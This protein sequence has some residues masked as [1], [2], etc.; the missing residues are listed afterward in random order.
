MR[1]W[2]LV[3]ALM[4][5]GFAQAQ[6]EAAPPVTVTPPPTPEEQ[7]KELKAVSTDPAAVKN[8]TPPTAAFIVGEGFRILSDDGDYKLRVGFQGQLAYQPTF[9]RAPDG[10][11]TNN[12]SQFRVPFARLRVDGHLFK[13][14]IR[15]WFSFEF[16]N[17]PPFLLDGYVEWMPHKMFGIRL[18]Q[19]WTPMSRHEYLG[20]Q[21]MLFPD[22]AVTA[23]Y[24]W[25]GRDKGVQLF[26]EGDLIWWYLALFAGS[27]QRQPFTT[28][29]NFQLQARVTVNP[30][31]PLGWA[32]LPFAMA[33]DGKVPLRISFNLQGHIGKVAPTSTGFNSNN[34]FF[35][36][37]DQPERR[38]QGIAADFTMQTGRFAFL[39]EFYSR[40]IESTT[41][42]TPAFWAIG[43]WAQA[44]YTFYKQVLDFALR[45]NYID[46]S[47]NLGNDNFYSGE[48]LLNWYVKAP[49]VILRARY[50]VAHQQDP[51]A[52]PADNPDLFTIVTLP[53]GPGWGHLVS[54][55]ASVYF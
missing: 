36:R 7:K 2:S 20:P 32:E 19:F 27:N 18:G 3:A 43:A 41:T 12:W 21:E 52:A 55:N 34:G 29:G 38:Q 53:T 39:T 15:Y 23:D 4:A 17:F 50:A 54:L 16:N 5:A 1:R 6:E 47:L 24:F 37:T 31:G 42:P 49:Y 26:G 10:T 8:P 45:F 22:W 25:T 51:G 14:Q 44:N 11:E 48:V 30:L 28:P 46:P 35:Q 40:R 9:I 33:K 13:P